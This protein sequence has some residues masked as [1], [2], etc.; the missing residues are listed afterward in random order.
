MFIEL[1]RPVTLLASM[2]S[3]LAVFHSAFLGAETDFH[4]RLY[5]SA[6]TLL[7]AAGFSLI[8]GLVFAQGSNLHD[9]KHSNREPRIA[10]TFPMLVFF[11]TTGVMLAIFLLAWYLETHCIFYRDVRY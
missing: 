8:S 9:A 3:L 4:Q 1:A 10:E 11:W 2:L 6:G 5:D 7:L